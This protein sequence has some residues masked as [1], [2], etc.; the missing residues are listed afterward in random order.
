MKVRKFLRFCVCVCVCV[1]ACACACVFKYFVH[2]YINLGLGL[3]IVWYYKCQQVFTFGAL[4]RSLCCWYWLLSSFDY[5][6]DILI[7][8]NILSNISKI[9]V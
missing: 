4:H 3:Y 8:V 1:C 5:N 2:I 7:V 6:N 9:K